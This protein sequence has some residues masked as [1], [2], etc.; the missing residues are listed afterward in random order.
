[1]PSS[2]SQS[3]LRSAVAAVC[4][5]LAQFS[6]TACSRD[7]ADAASELEG[8]WLLLPSPAT[9]SLLG[10]RAERIYAAMSGQIARL[11]ER[12]QATWALLDSLESSST[13]APSSSLRG[14]S[15]FLARFALETSARGA[16]DQATLKLSEDPAP[17]EG[18][19]LR[20]ERL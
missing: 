7:R 3:H 1:M 4:V 6:H 12:G 17:V 15:V 19:N 8:T 20:L 2:L 11:R 16:L 10:A 14:W 13:K 5:L 18:A 9:D